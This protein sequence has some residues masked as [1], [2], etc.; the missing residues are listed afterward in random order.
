VLINDNIAIQGV[1]VYEAPNKETGEPELKIGMPSYKNRGKYLDTAFP[2][3]SELRQELTSTVLAAYDEAL[4]YGRQAKHELEPEALDIHVSKMKPFEKDGSNLKAFCQVTINQEIV[5]RNIYLYEAPNKETG[6]LELKLGMPSRQDGYGK[7]HNVVHAVT[8][9]FHAELK[10]AVIHK[11]QNPDKIIGNTP[12][13]KLGDDLKHIT[14]NS[15]FV[16]NFLADY[17]DNAVSWSGKVDGAE[18]S[19]AVN[20]RDEAALSEALE[21][22][23][24]AGIEAANELTSNDLDEFQRIAAAQIEGI[25]K[26][27]ETEER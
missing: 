3:T 10:E 25:I 14:Q 19:I 17:L 1:K 4:M 9:R 20:K 16:E 12:Y 7:Y 24:A 6:E 23:I 18:T 27:T 2:V 8:P 15:Q 13:E 5:I 26:E 21:A 22:A 11:Y